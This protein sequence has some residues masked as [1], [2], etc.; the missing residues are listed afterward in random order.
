MK[1]FMYSLVALVAVLALAACGS[2]GG[3]NTAGF[4]DIGDD[5]AE[6]MDAAVDDFTFAGATTPRAS[7][8]SVDSQALPACVSVSPNPPADA[9][10]DGMPNQATLTFTNC[11]RVGGAGAVWTLN[12]SRIF[13]DPDGSSA[14]NTT[15]GFD[16][17]IVTPGFV[18]EKRTPGGT[19]IKKMTRNGL[20]SPR[21]NAG[22][23]RFQHTL[24]TF[25]E[26][27]TGQPATNIN[28]LLLVFTP[29]AGQVIALNQPLPDGSVN[30]TGS[31]SHTRG[32]TNY[33][34]NVSTPTALQHSAAC[35]SQR[36]VAGQLRLVFAGTGPS[37]NLDITFNACG[38]APTLVFTP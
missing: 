36:F 10:G 11:T 4:N 37:G 34:V 2:S 24:T 1:Q 29:A 33:S 20:R 5:F 38:T 8:A 35:A 3:S 15:S 32:A 27:P 30:I 22:T 28:N 14:T 17:Q 26:R 12:G 25:V 31:F 16:M 13:S 23:I 21:L 19:L 7:A 18:F 6:D 9:D